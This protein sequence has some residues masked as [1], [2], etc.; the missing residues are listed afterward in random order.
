MPEKKQTNS[1]APKVTGVN[2]M[3]DFVMQRLPADK[4][5]T[6]AQIF[7]KSVQGDRNPIT[8]KNFSPQELATIKEL[9]RL[10]GGD[11]G[12]I[13]YSDYNNLAEAMKK[14]GQMPVS[15][16]PG[17]LSMGDTLG[18]IQTT[19]GRFKYARDANGNYIVQDAYD[20][21][22]PKSNEP[23]EPAAASGPYGLIREYAGAKMPPGR[24]RPINIKLGR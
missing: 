16:T 12:D 24:G 22:A 4:F 17:L 14:R 8:E 15:I 19:L 3:I 13:Q 5:P 11:A 20:F 10:K 7:L 1:L 21:N 18:N 23:Q 6:S 2:R 9:I